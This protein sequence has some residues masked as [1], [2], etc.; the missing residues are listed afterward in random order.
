MPAGG[1]RPGL[2]GGAGGRS[3]LLLLSLLCLLAYALVS[4]LGGGGGGG[5]RV[6]VALRRAEDALVNAHRRALR[7]AEGG[8]LFG[9]KVVPLEATLSEH[10]YW[11]RFRDRG[12]TVAVGGRG[13]SPRVPIFVL[14]KDRL[15]SLQELLLSIAET[16]EDPYEIVI[17]DDNSTYAPMVT[18]LTQLQRA[19]VQARVGFR[20]RGAFC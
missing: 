5:E 18:F 14:T 10:L 19:G 3:R 8:L 1:V 4:A 15:T 7:P 13:D 17:H 20:M 16:L 9:D 6:F 11:R 12:A 2:R